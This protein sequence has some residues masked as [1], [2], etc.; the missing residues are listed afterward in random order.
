MF[1]TA[2]GIR[3]QFAPKASDPKAKRT[4][5]KSCAKKFTQWK[6]EYRT[7]CP[8]CSVAR[9]DSSVEQAKSKSGPIYEKTVLK[10]F[11]YWRSEKHRLGI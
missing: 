11:A 7:S 5:C 6:Y 4:V 9:G 2:V 3:K 1:E 8:K 10:Q